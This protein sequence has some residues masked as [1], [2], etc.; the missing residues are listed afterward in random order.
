MGL[1]FSNSHSEMKELCNQV[2]NSILNNLRKELFYEIDL[3][4]YYLKDIDYR[5][6]CS[7]SNPKKRE[8]LVEQVIEE[9][10]LLHNNEE[11]QE[12]NQDECMIKTDE[13][14][15]NQIKRIELN[16]MLEG[17]RRIKS[18]RIGEESNNLANLEDEKIERIERIEEVKNSKNSD[19]EISRNEESKKS[20]PKKKEN[21]I[22]FLK[23]KQE[24][25][26]KITKN[27]GKSKIQLVT[28]QKN[29]ASLNI[30]SSSIEKDKKKKENFP[31][32]KLK[33]IK[34]LPIKTENDKKNIKLPTLNER[35][36][37]PSKNSIYSP[38]NEESKNSVGLLPNEKKLLRSSNFSKT[39]L[40]KCVELYQ[41]SECILKPIKSLRKR[42]NIRSSNNIKKHYIEEE[43][44]EITALI[45]KI[46]K[47]H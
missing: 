46:K 44:D 37:S 17:Q 22:C 39:R 27:I 2:L 16:L 43:K 14:Y 10:K 5:T 33:K 11:E 30:S 31:L 4:Q 26:N 47:S 6:L 41:N 36:E 29:S 21:E 32:K 35:S 7:W 9:I 38:N 15:L 25:E 34:P 8:A 42:S 24:R 23:K 20:S 18:K 28:Q 3:L 45:E 13:K 12:A 19:L 1:G 40:N